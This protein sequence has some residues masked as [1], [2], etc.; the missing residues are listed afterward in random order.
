MIDRRPALIARCVDVADVIAAVNFGLNAGQIVAACGGGDN[1][2][3]LGTVASS[4]QF[5]PGGGKTT[6]CIE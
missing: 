1:G 3:G 2:P 6:Y 4:P 5:S